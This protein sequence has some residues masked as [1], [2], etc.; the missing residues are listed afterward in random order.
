[1]LFFSRNYL[2]SFKNLLVL[3]YNR[4]SF[5]KDFH[6]NQNINQNQSELELDN[7]VTVSAFP[8]NKSLPHPPGLDAAAE[9]FTM[10]PPSKKRGII[11]KITPCPF[12]KS[13]DTLSSP[14]QPVLD[15]DFKIGNIELRVL[16]Y[17]DQLLNLCTRTLTHI[18][19]WSFTYST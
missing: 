5:K 4:A 15:K 11:V 2:R 8:N 12:D 3:T 17:M 9:E 1:M 6:Q 10:E 13:Y 16:V 7:K 18:F 14:Q 19:S